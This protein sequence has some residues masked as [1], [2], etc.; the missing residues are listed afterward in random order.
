MAAEKQ[1]ILL[2]A[3]LMLS[4]LA[5]YIVTA[6]PEVVEEAVPQALNVV[7]YGMSAMGLG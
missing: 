6:N 2:L 5:Q 7:R 1:F 3:S 4:V